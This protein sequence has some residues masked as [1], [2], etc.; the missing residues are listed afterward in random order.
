MNDRPKTPRIAPE[1]RATA[2]E[3]RPHRGRDR[4]RAA[5]VAAGLALL[6]KN[7]LADIGVDDIARLA[8]L[9]KATFYNHFADKDELAAAVVEHVRFDQRALILR[10]VEKIDDAARSLARAFCVALRYRL[11]HPGRARLLEQSAPPYKAAVD[12]INSGVTR[13]VRAGLHEGRFTI[14]NVEVGVI[15]ILG[16]MHG[17]SSFSEPES[18]FVYMM[19]AQQL[20]ALMLRALGL[21]VAEAEKIAAQ[22]ADIAFGPDAASADIVELARE[23]SR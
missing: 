18:T 14:P 17:C 8:G 16:L 1:P 12:P 9:A 21:P 5:F 23:Q 20:S 2:G 3:A 7:A 13:H 4:N 10:H 15:A 19:R 11:D 22:E 6:E